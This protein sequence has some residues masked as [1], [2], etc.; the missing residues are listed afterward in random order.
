MSESRSLRGY[1]QVARFPPAS[2]GTDHA[3]RIHQLKQA[4]RKPGI[5]CPLFSFFHKL[6]YRYNL[7]TY[8]YNFCHIQEQY[9]TRLVAGGSIFVPASMVRMSGA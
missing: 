3:T 6:Y 8:I 2:T 1:A 7:D 4:R 9:L 5:V